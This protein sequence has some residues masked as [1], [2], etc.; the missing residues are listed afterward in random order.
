MASEDDDLDAAERALGTLPP[1][2]GSNANRARQA[3][4]ENRLTKLNDAL[5]P[6]QPSEDLFDRIKQQIAKD[7]D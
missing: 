2:E 1:G 7:P 3:A 5:P 4:W 6:E